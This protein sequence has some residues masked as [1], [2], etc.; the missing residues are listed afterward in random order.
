MNSVAE[1]D[2]PAQLLISVPKRNFKRAVDRNLIKRQIRESF[3]QNKEVLYAFLG[4]E[5]RHCSFAIVFAA[6]SKVSYAELDTTIV[7]A[8]K[9]LVKEMKDS[10]K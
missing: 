1:S 10:G 9:R 6:R 5:N 3:R 7:L 2:S 8:L 4:S